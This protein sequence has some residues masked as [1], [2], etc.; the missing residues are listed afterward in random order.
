MLIDAKLVR[1]VQVSII[2][3]LVKEIELENTVFVKWESMMI[4]KMNY[5]K[6]VMIHVY[7]V[8]F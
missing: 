6:I 2:V 5:V 8:I 3:K 1:M 4:I 7:T